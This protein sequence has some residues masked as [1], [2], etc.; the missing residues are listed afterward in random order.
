M[1]KYKA[2][3]KRFFLFIFFLNHT[4]VTAYGGELRYMMRYELRPPSVVIENKPDVVLQGNDILLEHYSQTGALPRVPSTVLV[5][6]REVCSC[7]WISSI[8]SL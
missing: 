1:Q 5:P 6:F 2:F 3:V 4:K 7:C 8:V